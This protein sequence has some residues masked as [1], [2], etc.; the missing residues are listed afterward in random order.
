MNDRPQLHPMLKLALDLGPLLLFFFANAKPAL[1]E[2][3]IAPLIPAAVATGE[4]SGIFV[5]TAVFMVAILVALA[6]SYALTRRLPVM[7]V[8]SAIIVV[9]FGGATLFFQNETFIK[10]K[11]TIIYLLFAGTL[12]GGLIL[13]KPL[14][15]MVFDQMF[16]L[17]EEG[18]RKLTIRWAL[19]FLVLAVLNEIVWRTQTTD[20][21]VTFKVFGVT[22]LTFIFAALQYP[23]LMKYDRQRGI[24]IAPSPEGVRSKSQDGDRVYLR[25]PGP[26]RRSP[27]ALHHACAARYSRR[28]I[29][30]RC[31]RAL[32]SSLRGPRPLL[33][34]AASSDRH[35]LPPVEVFLDHG[36]ALVSTA[37]T[38]S[39]DTVP[40]GAMRLLQTSVLLPDAPARHTHDKMADM[41]V[42]F[43]HCSL[44]GCSGNRVPWRCVNSNVAVQWQRN[45]G[46][47]MMLFAA[48]QEIPMDIS[49]AAALAG[50]LPIRPT[51]AGRRWLP[52]R[53]ADPL[54]V[55]ALQL[56]GRPGAAGPATRRLLAGRRCGAP[57][58]TGLIGGRI[59]RACADPAATTCRGAPGCLCR[60]GC[61]CNP[62][63]RCWPGDR[64]LRR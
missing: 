31:S 59:R 11:P 12:F 5:A 49:A 52:P 50:R 14:L 57:L 62:G 23:L 4:R 53:R 1:F 33:R 35:R 15:A 63:C 10:L 26:C 28:R 44:L 56:P 38:S 13:R 41:S 17:T 22:P 8:V 37:S 46:G 48:P 40:G 61:R 6:I 34:L 54:Q 32:A 39:F 58:L 21:W 7:A 55:R 47:S 64:R 25:R 36:G 43:A 18:W 29:L 19:F 30:R 27:R 9:V 3:W 2:P 20:T 24:T 16:H 60:L 51:P 45:Y 42:V